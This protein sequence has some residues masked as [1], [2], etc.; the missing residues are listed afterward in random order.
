MKSVTE[1]TQEFFDDYAWTQEPRINF[2][3]GG[4]Y[5]TITRVEWLFK[6]QFDKETMPPGL[7]STPD[8]IRYS[9][10]QACSALKDA[11]FPEGSAAVVTNGELYELLS[12]CKMVVDGSGDPKAMLEIVEEFVNSTPVF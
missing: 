3:T 6:M 4:V 12:K 9:R 7:R 11:I 5:T 2:D 1:I 10:V 8:L